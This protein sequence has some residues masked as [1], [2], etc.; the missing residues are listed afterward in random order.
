ML[1]TSATKMGSLPL[2]F[3][4]EEQK[5]GPRTEYYPSGNWAQECGGEAE[6]LG[7]PFTRGQQ[8]ANK[9]ALNRCSFG[10]T[11]WEHPKNSKPWAIWRRAGLVCAGQSTGSQSALARAAR[12]SA[13]GSEAPVPLLLR[14]AGGSWWLSTSG[15]HF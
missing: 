5:R 2:D 9:I 4:L 15:I 8:H 1:S 6:V 11:R 3:P 7:H 13:K 14:D 12:L 10:R